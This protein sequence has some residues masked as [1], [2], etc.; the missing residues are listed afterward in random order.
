MAKETFKYAQL[1]GTSHDFR[2]LRLLGS[3]GGDIECELVH[4]TFDAQPY[5]ALSYCWGSSELVES[6]KVNS[7]T[8]RITDSLQAALLHLRR[9]DRDRVLWIDAVCINQTDHVERSHQVRKMR[10]IYSR[11]HKVVVWLGKA[12]VAVEAL[13]QWVGRLN[14]QDSTFR[15]GVPDEQL[16]QGLRTLLDRPWFSRVWILQEIA[17]ARLAEI[18]AGNYSVPASA[19]ARASEYSGM[20]IDEHCKSVLDLMRRTAAAH[21]LDTEPF[22]EDLISLA[23]RFQ[24]CKATD[25]RDKIFALQG[26]CRDDRIPDDLL[27][28][29]ALD[30]AT[31][32]RRLS[33]HFLETEHSD[34]G[35]VLDFVGCFRTVTAV[36]LVQTEQSLDEWS[37][38][39][40][41]SLAQIK[42]CGPTQ[43]IS[44]LCLEER[45]TSED[46]VPL[47]T[48][49]T[50]VIQLTSRPNSVLRGIPYRGQAQN[51]M[52]LA[53]SA[54]S[55]EAVE[56]MFR[57]D[58]LGLSH[59]LDWI[60]GHCSNDWDFLRVAVDKALELARDAMILRVAKS[61]GVI[62]AETF[63]SSLW[64]ALVKCSSRGNEVMVHALLDVGTH[65]NAVDEPGLPLPLNEACR[66]GHTRIVGMLLDAGADVNSKGRY[67]YTPLH[68][69]CASEEKSLE[70]V[71]MLLG[72]G[73]DVHA[74]AE[75][76]STALH[77]ASN[78]GNV[79]VMRELLNAG[80]DVN[81]SGFQWE[82]P[83]HY[84]S[85][86]DNVDVMREL[87]NEGA[88]MN[89]ID[90]QGN[91]PLQTAVSWKKTKAIRLLL[92]AG[93]D[94]K[95]ANSRAIK[96]PDEEVEFA[97]EEGES[98]IM[99]MLLDA[100]VQIEMRRSCSTFYEE[101]LLNFLKDAQRQWKSS[102][103][104]LREIRSRA[105]CAVRIES[106]K[107]PYRGP[108]FLEE[109][110]SS[111]ATL[112][113][114]DP[115]E[116]R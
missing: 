47:E 15:K 99:N 59:L 52:L 11:A 83:L 58:D 75:F 104:R 44:L 65:A 54:W 45:P 98:S 71:K 37:A 106:I 72:L 100:G 27:P 95:A 40:R 56:A 61:T 94:M 108:G 97:V 16:R 92:D 50:E 10:E 63:A 107:L 4:T 33:N 57:A 36:C 35:D 113:G 78:R 49:Y 53:Y 31:V 9:H 80:A 19:F 25:E 69:A 88:D 82:T 109:S 42:E 87:L 73:A 24:G 84:A 32:V 85:E 23:I 7:T 77:I 2:L 5:E 14:E 30:T 116:E 29:Y 91:T 90:S 55:D 103:L 12:T 112:L 13:M 86:G 79:D 34:I 105:G 46:D 67:S 93:A 60:Y 1:D 48:C 3:S 28:D 102:G 51:I 43:K 17:N 115:Q 18:C 111:I 38:N 64:K 76:D 89:A 68:E 66:G 101:P 22:D 62:F 39:P 110:S 114:D 26:L 74:Q 20:R 96:L 81:A 41:G 70:L 8:L 21:D 6:M